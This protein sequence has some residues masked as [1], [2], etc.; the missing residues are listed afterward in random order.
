MTYI[1]ATLSANIRQVEGGMK[2]LRAF[3]DLTDMEMTYENVCQVIEDVRRIERENPVTPEL[4]LRHV[5]KYYG[6]DEE[7]LAGPQR[8]RNVALPR[9]IAMYLIRKLA[10][11]SISRIAA[12]FHRDNATVLHSMKKVEAQLLLK[13]NKLDAVIRDI[14]SNIESAPY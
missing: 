11:S 13:E 4:V 7:L 14:T 9:Q 12:I 8:A 1:A 3:H 6:L 5:C 2:K 10:G